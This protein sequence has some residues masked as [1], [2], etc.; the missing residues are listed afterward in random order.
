MGEGFAKDQRVLTHAVHLNAACTRNGVRLRLKREPEPIRKSLQQYRLRIPLR[1]AIA[2]GNLGE[3]SFA[4]RSPR[5]TRDTEV[6]GEAKCDVQPCPVRHPAT[7]ES[8]ETPG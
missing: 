4:H 6:S 3:A 5:C 1:R 2:W 7:H 8:A